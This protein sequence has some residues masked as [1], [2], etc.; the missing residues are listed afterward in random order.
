PGDMKL[1]DFNDLT[2]FGVEDPRM[3]TIGGVVFRYLDRLPVVGDQISMDGLI[4]TV[5]EMEGHRILRVRV[6]KGPPTEEGT[7]DSGEVTLPETA[8]QPDLTLGVL[9][10]NGGQRHAASSGERQIQAGAI[11]EGGNAAELCGTEGSAEVV[12][13]PSR[14]TAAPTKPVTRRPDESAS[15]R[16]RDREGD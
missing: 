8:E 5:L 6:S 13:L 14:T 16:Q 2:N 12:V 9:T 7:E 10:E 1:T 15:R 4:A 3:T 11:G